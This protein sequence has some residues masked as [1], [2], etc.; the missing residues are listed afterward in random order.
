[1]DVKCLPTLSSIEY[2]RRFH[3]S[4]K[5]EVGDLRPEVGFCLRKFINNV[6]I[7]LFKEVPIMETGVEEHT[8]RHYHKLLRSS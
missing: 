1:M 3:H 2:P 6:V 7:N 8:T 4:L 5:F